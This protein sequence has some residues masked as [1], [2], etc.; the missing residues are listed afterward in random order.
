MQSRTESGRPQLDGV[1]DGEVE[2][3]LGRQ[4]DE[5]ETMLDAVP[6]MV[7]YKDAENRIL[8]ANRAAAES[9]GKLPAE[10]AGASAYDLYPDEAAQYH[11]DDLE[12]I[13]S[14]RPKLGILERLPV[15]SGEKRWVRS[16]K[17]PL[18]DDRGEI[19]GVIVFRVD[20]TEHKRAEE[21]LEQAR[22]ELER[23]VRERTAELGEVVESLRAEI[24]GRKRAEEQARRQQSELAHV[25]RLQTVEGIAAQLAHEINQPLGAIANFA[26]GLAARLENGATDRDAMLGAARQIAK[27]ALRAGQFIHRLRSFARKDPPKRLPHDLNRLAR[28]AGHL[29]EPDARHHGI[30]V[31]VCLDPR[32]PVV[33]VDEILIE[34]VIL[35]LLRNGLEAIVESGARDGELLIETALAPPVSVELRVSDTG[36]GVPPE[37]REKLFD[38]FFTTKEEGLG[39]GL[40][41]S[42]S[43]V[44]AHGGS[45]WMTSH[46]GRGARFAFALPARG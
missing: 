27:Q 40:S 29:I 16:D 12:V 35:N 34:Q 20:V 6:A 21:A 2:R 11:R 8:R 22:D 43:I 1:A 44:E 17:I 28:E 15:H 37:V 18:R 45:M 32:L 4:R 24:A 30:A 7:W 9:I 33:E 13:R 36:T 14:G 19:V 31:R 10:L 42:R 38:P 41:I 26:N 39:M 25:L 23:R 5:L 3:A 46:D